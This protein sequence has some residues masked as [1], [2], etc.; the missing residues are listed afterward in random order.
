M[1]FVSVSPNASTLYGGWS[2][3]GAGTAHAALSDGSTSSYIV[4]TAGPYGIAIL[5]FP[6]ISVPAG[7]R[8]TTAYLRLTSGLAST[9]RSGEIKP[10]FVTA[11]GGVLG[12][13]T[14]TAQVVNWSIPQ[15]TNVATIQDP[16]GVPVSFNVPGPMPVRVHEATAYLRYVSKPVAAT[17]DLGSDTSYDDRPLFRW[18]TTL[19]SDGGDV[20]RVEFGVWPGA[21]TPGTDPA[22][23]SQVLDG[24]AFESR[25]PAL[26]NGSWK[27]AVRVAQ[28]VRGSLFWS[29][30]KVTAFSVSV[31]RPGV[32]LLDPASEDALGYVSLKITEQAGSGPSDWYE[33][34][35][36]NDGVTEWRPVV[37]TEGD[38][39]A[40]NPT[41][42]VPDSELVIGDYEPPN[43]VPRF[44]RAR[45]VTD[46]GSGY[47]TAS[48]WT[49]VGSGKWRTNAWW[50][51]SIQYPG[52][53]VKV[54]VA[55]QSG[56]QSSG[57]AGVFQGL[58][59]ADNVVVTDSPTP[60]SGEIVF[61]V[62][63]DIDR[64]KLEELYASGDPIL[65]QATPGT[66]WQDRWV[67]LIN[68]NRTPAVDKLSVETS[69]EQFEWVEIP[70][71]V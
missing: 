18:S 47:T 68:H 17:L 53:N 67:K 6:A 13:S 11:G 70:R 49:A 27:A 20:T 69:L 19:D 5:S 14:Q 42:G 63:T 71:P 65:V 60:P 38:G 33:L 12:T 7:A 50:L 62:D 56:W 58:G 16:T 9:Y 15:S 51:K 40:T 3:V 55:S 1:T 61:D 25:L 35:V 10:A 39:R 48:A 24:T 57:R 43:N 52:R 28:T 2:V 34:E 31:G 41:P 37:T 44:Y 36:S 32:P 22:T 59:S 54:T 66:H 29:D 30:W 45:A 23:W 8:L 64:R 26:A 21:A 46:N 4:N